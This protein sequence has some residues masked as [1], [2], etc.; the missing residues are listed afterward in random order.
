MIDPYV[1]SI[2]RSNVGPGVNIEVA[3]WATEDSKSRPDY[4]HRYFELDVPVRLRGPEQGG[5]YSIRADLLLIYL[6]HIRL[7]S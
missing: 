1:E 7:T 3:E 4:Y 2:V 5:T 6:L